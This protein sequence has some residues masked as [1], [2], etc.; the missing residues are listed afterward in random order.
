MNNQK[1][2][3]LLLKYHPEYGSYSYDYYKTTNA[4]NNKGVCSLT[5]LF[6]S[7]F[8]CEEYDLIKAGKLK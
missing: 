3:K 8:T 4:I 7:L 5:G 2:F 1:L 6:M